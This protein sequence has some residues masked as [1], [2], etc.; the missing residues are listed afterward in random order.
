LEPSPPVH[1]HHHAAAAPIVP[2]SKPLP[3]ATLA[4]EGEATCVV[5]MQ[6][7]PNVAIMPCSHLHCCSDCIPTVQSTSNK[8]PTCRQNI[9]SVIGVF[10]A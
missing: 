6:N 4:K 9:S 2:A 1:H 8:C 5:C 7:K 3:P 10:T